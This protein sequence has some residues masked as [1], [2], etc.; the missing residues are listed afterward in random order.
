MGCAIREIIEWTLRLDHRSRV[1]NSIRTSPVNL[2][3]RI[4]H[5]PYKRNFVT[6][7]GFFEGEYMATMPHRGLM[8]LELLFHFNEQTLMNRIFARI[9][10][11]TT[12]GI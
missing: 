10:N 7:S 1:A 6:A 9:Y 4:C 2:H 12:E 11:P 5:P 3:T 8:T